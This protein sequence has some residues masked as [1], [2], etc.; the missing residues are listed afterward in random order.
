MERKTHSVDS[1]KGKTFVCMKV[2]RERNIDIDEMENMYDFYFKELAKSIYNFEHN[3]YF[4][5]GIGTFQITA[6]KVHEY[7]RFYLIRE[8]KHLRDKIKN[9]PD[10]KWRER[11]IEELVEHKALLSKLYALRHYNPRDAWQV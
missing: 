10:S 4:M 6:K 9:Y 1:S 5:R 2:A 8:T 7:L 11:Y 3:A